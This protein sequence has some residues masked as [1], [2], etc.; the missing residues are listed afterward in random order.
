V[1]VNTL[2]KNPRDLFDE[3]EGKKMVELGSGDVKYHQGFSSNL[4]T[5]GGE[6]HLAL[7]F[8][9]SHMEI[10]APVVEG[11]ARARH[12]PRKARSIDK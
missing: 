2:G 6:V 9:P 4:M 10:V 12:D 7:A 5:S 3:F 1:L 11:A 8:N